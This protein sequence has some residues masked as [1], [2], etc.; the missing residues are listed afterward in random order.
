[1][2][3]ELKKGGLRATA[4]T[5]GGELVS[6]RD[7]GGLEYIWEGDPAFWPGQN[8]ILFPIV[9]SL[10]DGRVD[11][12]G[13]AYEMGRHGFA[14]RSEFSLAEQGEDFVTLELRE[15]EETLARYPFPFS[16][17]V[18]HRLLDD[19]FST[20]FTVKNTGTAH[21]PFCIGGHTAIRC[22]LR[23]GERFEDYELLFEEPEHAYS[24]LLSPE[25]LILHDGWRPMLNEGETIPLDYRPFQEMDTII[26]SMLR[27]GKVSLV[28]RKTGRG[29]CLDF[30]EFPM[31]AFWTTPGA[32]YLCLEPWQGCAA[33]DN[34]SGKFEDKPFCVIL[35]PDREK[36]LTY[37]FRIE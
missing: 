20:T 28:H 8:P 1:M 23:S 12:N 37:A 27:S 3:F 6:L 7:S 4:Q 24:H 31:V 30:H 32:P 17:Q 15:N 16:L 34:E 14:R 9:G 29:V 2:T 36:S 11:I 33:Y 22:P 25:G 21:M 5:K 13:T 19:G 18:T 26:F 10:K 35:P